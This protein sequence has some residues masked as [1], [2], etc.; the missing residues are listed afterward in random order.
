MV[1]YTWNDQPDHDVVPGLVN[2]IWGEDNFICFNVLEKGVIKVDKDE[3][4]EFVV[5]WD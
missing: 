3:Y 2:R 4:K 1:F 5:K